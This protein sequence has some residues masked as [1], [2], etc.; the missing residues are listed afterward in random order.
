VSGTHNG[1]NECVE[2]V[3]F[4]SIKSVVDD[5]T[6]FE[7]ADTPKLRTNPEL[8][9]TTMLESDLHEEDD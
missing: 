2:F 7:L 5:T 4:M 1:K 3:E 6:P 9:L 8:D